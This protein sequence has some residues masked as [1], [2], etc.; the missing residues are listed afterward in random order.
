VSGKDLLSQPA[1]F[2]ELGKIC[3]GE[4][5]PIGAGARSRTGVRF[6]GGSGARSP[7]DQERPAFQRLGEGGAV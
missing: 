2:G 6:Q 4:F 1:D 3:E 5:D 7:A